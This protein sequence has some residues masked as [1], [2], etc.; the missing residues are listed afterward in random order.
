[1]PAEVPATHGVISRETAEAMARAAREQL[2]ADLGLGLTGIAGGE[3]VEGQRPG[4]MHIALTDGT[5]VAY[6]SSTY[7]QG[8][9]AAKRRA[10]TQALNLLRNWLLR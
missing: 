6:E 1:V 8:R 4:T 9:D 10:V 7:Y 2:H 3:E 5:R